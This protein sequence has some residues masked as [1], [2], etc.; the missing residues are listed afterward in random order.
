MNSFTNSTVAGWTFGIVTGPGGRHHLDL[1][2]TSIAELHPSDQPI[3][4]IV[5]GPG[6]RPVDLPSHVIYKVFKE[7]VLVRPSRRSLRVALHTRNILD[8]FSRT[9]AICHKKNLLANYSSY[10]KLCVLH[11]Y[12][13]L[14]PDWLQSWSSASMD[15]DI[16]L[17]PVY[18][19]HNSRHRDWSVCDY[20]G[21]GSASLPY[22]YPQSKF[23]FISGT[24]FCVK[25][26]FFRQN[27]LDE[28]LFWGEGED[29]IWSRQVRSYAQIYFNR[30]TSVK[31]SKQKDDYDID[32]MNS[33][34]KPNSVKL[35]KELSCEKTRNNIL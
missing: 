27:P 13:L 3:E 30:N 8:F 33:I 11:D 19:L 5:V 16:A 25:T 21:I 29:V 6:P 17:T 20:P 4:I 14:S 32:F 15:W 22:D 35:A 2:L 10:D 31:Y 18:D 23:H 12:V 1:V 28:T 24:Y 7:R 26:A 9:G 34:W